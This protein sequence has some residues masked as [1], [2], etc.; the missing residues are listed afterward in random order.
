MLIDSKGKDT[1]EVKE[2]RNTQGYGNPRR[3]YGSIGIFLDLMGDDLY[4]GNGEN[5]LYWIINSKW[6]I[7]LDLEYW[8][9][10]EIQQDAE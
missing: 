9:I 5:N 4:K 1:Y 8:Q 2:T 10:E 3:D 6:G 7:G